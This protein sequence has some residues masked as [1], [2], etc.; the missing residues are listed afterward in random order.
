MLDNSF[1]ACAFFFFFQW[2]LARAHLL[3]SLGQ[4]QSTVAQRGETT[5]AECSLT[6]CVRARFLIDSHTL[7]EQ[8]HSQPTPTPMTAIHNL[9]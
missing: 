9:H 4:D 5:E 6:S 7:P 3:H 8:R 2:R 1:P